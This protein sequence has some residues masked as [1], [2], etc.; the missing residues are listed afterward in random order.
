LNVS[1]SLRRKIAREAATLLYSGVEK[2]YKQAKLKAAKTFGVH[3]LPTNLEVVL[4]FDKIAEENE[5][6]A[7]IERLV[8][9]RVE[10]LE[11][12]RFLKAYNPRLVG[13]VWRGVIHRESDIDVTVYCDE[14]EAILEALKQNNL[15]ILRTEW[16]AVTKKGQK[17]TSFHIYFESPSKEK[18]EI[19]VRSPDEVDF[20]DKCEIYGDE[21]TGLRL[22]EL[23]KL[24]GENPA[25]RFVP[26]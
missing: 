10:A 26:V 18:V 13:S 23:E 24:L 16:S 11:L 1:L 2:E 17:R 9:M 6:P 8:K 15:K 4:E 7:R 25:Q 21:I 12:L 14:S 22:R 19:T 5:G 3:F 20:K